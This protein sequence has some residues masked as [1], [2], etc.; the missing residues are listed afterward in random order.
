V[1]LL[2]AKLANG[3]L[4]PN[5]PYNNPNFTISGPPK[6]PDDR[7][8]TIVKITTDGPWSGV[9]SDGS[10]LTSSYDGVGNKAIR[11]SCVS[12]SGVY[13]AVIQ[14]QVDVGTLGNNTLYWYEC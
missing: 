1:F 12:G 5:N 8:W 11:L 6:P 7:V 4:N 9:I 3:Q 14:K 13:S 2:G 10:E